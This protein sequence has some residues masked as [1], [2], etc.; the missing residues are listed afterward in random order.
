MS[1]AIIP[2]VKVVIINSLFLNGGIK[3]ERRHFIVSD[4]SS[5]CAKKYFATFYLA[6]FLFESGTLL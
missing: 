4:K 5:Q 1:S 3:V 2:L 6:R